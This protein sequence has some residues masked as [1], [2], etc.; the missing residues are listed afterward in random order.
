MTRAELWNKAEKA[1]KRGNSCVAREAEFSLPHQLPHATHIRMT[2]EMAQFVVDRHGFAADASMHRPTE[3]NDKRN[4]HVHLLQT[5]RRMKTDGTLGEKCRELDAAK[6]GG[7]EI[8]EWRKHWAEICNRQLERAGFSER[9]DHRSNIDRGLEDLPTKHVGKG[10]YASERAVRNDEIRTENEINAEMRVLLK[11]RAEA[12]AAL[13]AAEAEAL[14]VA[15]V[16]EEPEELQPVALTESEIIAIRK[17]MDAQ[18]LEQLTA[19]KAA[20][21]KEAARL[22]IIETEGRKRCQDAYP[23]SMI[24]RAKIDIKPINKNIINL[25]NSVNIL[26]DS[27]SDLNRL[28]SLS[29]ESKLRKK[30]DALCA[31]KDA[32]KQKVQALQKVAG[33]DSREAIGR[34]LTD[35]AYEQGMLKERVKEIE[36]DI[37]AM[38]PE[39]TPEDPRAKRYSEMAERY[40]IW[41]EEDRRSE[42]FVLEPEEQQQ[43]VRQRG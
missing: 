13:K 30:V 15:Q 18:R 43:Y 6:T 21:E 40:Q 4:H 34:V 37:M 12:E 39:M 33:S 41:K 19:E 26:K 1:E 23:E 3:K 29:K 36:I 28:A 32:K 5:T 22:T 9:V 27:I 24:A 42:E 38:T 8:V 11:E 25:N 2:D 16:K 35:N 17:E 7:P 31:D 14:A 20:T 10:Q